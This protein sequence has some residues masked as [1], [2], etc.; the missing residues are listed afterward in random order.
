MPAI[1][2]TII[3]QTK[4]F[5]VVTLEHRPHIPRQDGGHIMICATEKY[6]PDRTALSPREAVELMRLSMMAA[7]AYPAAMELQG[8]EI[9]RINFQ[10]NGN[11]A[12]LHDK[13]P[14][15]HLH[16]YGRTRRSQTQTWGEALYFPDPHDPRY[17]RFEPL[18]K[19]DCEAIREKLEALAK[20]PRYS[21]EMWGLK[22][23]VTVKV[24][25]R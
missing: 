4:T 20:E 19:E 12:L 2:G 21:D 10:E 3:Y 15:F 18:T 13:P 1:S 17:A 9:E 11:W 8:V 6:F 22:E 24:K 25:K 14:V 7:E 16:L 23:N 5:S